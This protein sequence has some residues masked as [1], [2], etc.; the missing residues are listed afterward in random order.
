M[1]YL[2]ITKHGDN[3]YTAY[4]PTAQAWNT[5]STKIAAVGGLVLSHPRGF[6]IKIVDGRTFEGNNPRRR[7]TT[8][9]PYRLKGGKAYRVRGKKL[10]ALKSKKRKS[11]RSRR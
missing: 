7:K 3:E 10:I 4:S 8:R 9:A 6:G 5:E 1:S 2:V 11:R